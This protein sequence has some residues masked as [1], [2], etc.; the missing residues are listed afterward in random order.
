METRLDAAGAVII[1]DATQLHQ[2]ATNLCTNA[3]QAM[4]NGG[5]LSVDLDRIDVAEARRLSHGTLAPGLYVR[6]S[7]KDTGSGIPQPVLDREYST[8][9]SPPRV[10]ARE[11]V[12][13]CPWCTA[14]LRI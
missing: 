10:S 9:S 1:G 3:V 13:A 12:S 7:V 4:Q 2:V 8:R 11:P 14:S 6:L 5:L